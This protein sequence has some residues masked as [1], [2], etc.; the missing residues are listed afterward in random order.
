M[1]LE[2]LGRNVMVLV[3]LAVS[4]TTHTNSGTLETWVARVG[5]NVCTVL[6]IH[7]HEVLGMM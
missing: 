7:D 4:C 5:P 2:Q 1:C 3:K 6:Y